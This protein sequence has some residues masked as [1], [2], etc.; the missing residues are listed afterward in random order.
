MNQ[1]IFVT[2]LLMSTL[3]CAAQSKRYLLEET[4]SQRGMQKE[5]ETTQK[6]YCAAVVRGGAPSCLVFAPTTLS[7]PNHYWIL[8]PFTSFSH[9]DQGTYTSR[10]MTPEEAQ[11]LGL[12]RNPTIASGVESIIELKAPLDSKPPDF[13]EIVLITE[14]HVTAG[15]G[16]AF[17]KLL[18]EA[19]SPAT[20]PMQTYQT[21]VDGDPDRLFILQPLHNFAELDTANS[22]RSALPAAKRQIFD[23]AFEKYVRSSYV[24]VMRYRQDLSAI[25]K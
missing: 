8:L 5:Y 3:A 18:R 15:D 12:R 14:V 13:S 2:A 4:N 24:T 7:S 21:V 1:S 25:A 6:E 19:S 9:Y 10:G 23:R 20:P 17:L 11:N 22:I 16:P